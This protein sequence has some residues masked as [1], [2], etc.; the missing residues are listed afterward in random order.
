MIARSAADSWKNPSAAFNTTI[1][2]IAAASSVSP[3]EAE[4]TAA[5]TRSATRGST[6]CR[7][8]IAAYWG[9][10]SSCS[11]F[12]PCAASRV[13]ASPVLRPRIA[14]VESATT[15]ENGSQACARSGDVATGPPPACG[16]AVSCEIIDLILAETGS[17]GIGASTETR[18]GKPAAE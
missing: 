4:T 13:V 2:A 16:V 6:I 14:S 15:T 7:A 12:G 11:L 17:R 9:P 18:C 3:S 1:T 5:T 10:D 8:A